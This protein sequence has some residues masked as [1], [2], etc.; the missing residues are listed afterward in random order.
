MGGV[1]VSM[2]GG[3]GGSRVASPRSDVTYA[4]VQWRFVRLDHH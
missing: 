2:Y 1:I 4:S 3:G